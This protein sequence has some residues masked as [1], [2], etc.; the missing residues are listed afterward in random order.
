MGLPALSGAGA[1]ASIGVGVGA[2]PIVLSQPTRGGSAY[3]L[4]S[5]EVVNTGTQPADFRIAVK[6]LPSE[7]GLVVPPRWVTIVPPGVAL[8]PGQP[9]TSG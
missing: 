4:S 7:H 3:Q 5:L 9:P 2:A 6:H 8:A 1:G